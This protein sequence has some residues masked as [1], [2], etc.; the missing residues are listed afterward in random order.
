MKKGARKTKRKISFCFLISLLIILI[1]LILLK[2]IFG[3]RLFS[4]DIPALSL[5]DFS[6]ADI[7]VKDS[8][9]LL[10]ANCYGL[11][12]TTSIE[13]T[14][15][16]AKALENVTLL[17]PDAHDLFT[18]TIKN[19]GISILFVKIHSLKEGI[20]YATIFLKRSNDVLALDAKPSD[21]IAIALGAHSKI[22]IKNDLLQNAEKIC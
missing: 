9:I 11:V 18:Y 3:N 7:Q 4:A 10:T 16:I 19:F 22:Y 21:A 5:Q 2:L 13:Q 15:S 6:K 8:N 1:I 12:M 14:Q 20:Y 17:R